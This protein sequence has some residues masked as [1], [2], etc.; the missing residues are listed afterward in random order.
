[1]TNLAALSAACAMLCACGGEN[2]PPA[3]A[4]APAPVPTVFTYVAP[5]QGSAEVWNRTLTDS[6]GTSVA[7]QIRQTVTTVS[8]DGSMVWT[9]DDPT[10]TSVVED[11][12]TFRTVP[13]TLDL[14]ANGQALDYTQQST[15]GTPTHCV[16]AYPAN[17]VTAMAAEAG[18]AQALGMRHVA[19][20]QV[21][22]SWQTTYTITCG[23][24]APVT[25]S[26]TAGVFPA[27]TVAVPAGTFQAFR[28][29]V[30]TTWTSGANNEFSN[31][32]GTTAWRDTAHSL[33]TIKLDETIVH[34]DTS[35]PYI[36]H[37]VRE[38][39]RRE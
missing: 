13:E 19:S 17:L 16:Y 11:G 12:L 15:T 26:V 39:L 24:S 28:E 34:G 1:M 27:E 22:Q 20:L 10:G 35:R 32:T 6:A 30:S 2:A 38:L 23:A 33:F 14:A 9:Y 3:P 21:G 5:T 36:S 18:R 37:D 7:M 8:P 4:P 25:F 31:G 29:T